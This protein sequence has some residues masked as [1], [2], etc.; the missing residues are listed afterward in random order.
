MV[1]VR[2][3]WKDHEHPEVRGTAMMKF[4][5][6]SVAA[7]E[8]RR[9]QSTSTGRDYLISVALPF[10]YEDEPGRVW[11]VVYVLDANLYFGLVVDMVRAMNIR[12]EFCNELPDAFVVGIGY[13]VT[14]SLSQMLHEVMHRR[15]S[16]FLERREPESEQF[17]QEHFPIPS[18]S[19]SGDAAGFLHFIHRELVPLIESDYRIDPDDRT[20][21]GHSWGGGFVF[22]SLFRQPRL[23]R[24]YVVV[25]ATPNLG[26]E[27]EY[28]RQHERL[29]VR[30]HLVMEDTDND[31]VSKLTSFVNRLATRNYDG[32]EVSHELMHSTHCAV[33]PPAFQSGLVAVF[34]D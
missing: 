23:F 12:V 19:V 17:I 24:R 20:L 13:P 3:S 7:T 4:P 1:R 30:L 28:A 22:Y 18:P 15:L 9:V 27:E 8:A 10:H 14:G 11:P 29:P 31:E 33:V 25:S 32:L 26:D 6:A 34:S 2:S 5:N 21:L 16:D